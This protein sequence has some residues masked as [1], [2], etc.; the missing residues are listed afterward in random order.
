MQKINRFILFVLLICIFAIVCTACNSNDGNQMMIDMQEWN[1]EINLDING[2]DLGYVVPKER[3]VE[4]SKTM[5]ENVD[6][7]PNSEQVLNGFAINGAASSCSE[8]EN[9]TIYPDS[10]EV[11]DFGEN[12]YV[13]GK[14]EADDTIF[15]SK[16][17]KDVIVDS[18]IEF[19]KW[20]DSAYGR[21]LVSYNETK[22]IASYYVVSD[23]FNT[24][25]YLHIT[26]TFNEV[27]NEVITI[28]KLSKS[29]V[30]CKMFLVYIENERWT[31]LVEQ[32]NSSDYYDNLGN[33]SEY[34]LIECDLSKPETPVTNITYH[35]ME[36]VK[37]I[38]ED[39]Y[40]V[41]SADISISFF[42]EYP[43][44]VKNIGTGYFGWGGSI[45]DD[46]P[47]NYDMNN[48]PT[49]ANT[50]VYD[51]DGWHKL[52][53]R[54]GRGSRN[55]TTEKGK[56]KVISEPY[57]IAVNPLYLDGWLSYSGEPL[58]FVTAAGVVD[59]EIQSSGKLK[60]GEY[61]IGMAS[62][63]QK[64]PDFVGVSMEGRYPNA[65]DLKDAFS[66]M[67]MTE[68]QIDL[69]QATSRIF[70]AETLKNWSA[71]GK[72]DYSNIRVYMIKA[73]RNAF[74]K[75][76]DTIECIYSNIEKCNDNIAI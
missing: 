10:P 35:Y 22:D 4:H 63:S 18:E 67:G 28:N 71:L 33:F 54:S 49:Y 48:A 29:T 74:Y 52:I 1:T 25:E 15:F 19:N 30:C 68:K 66:Q 32:I 37:Y 5:L 50:Y 13:Q 3:Q 11:D 57:Y 41:D 55:T 26:S 39:N 70:S 34:A 21:I 42:D 56:A 36:G 27:G 59:R 20:F 44:V 8:G 47:K 45:R 17:I 12:F 43:T 24:V 38:S 76:S 6:N 62:T 65:D 60:V 14:T 2:H 58:S 16:Q 31:C 46:C 53:A 23:N 69:S 51:K 64:Y 40:T 9:N 7:C 73:M 61:E 75:S 72:S